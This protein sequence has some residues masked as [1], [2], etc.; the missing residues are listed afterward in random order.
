M[1]IPIKL[2]LWVPLLDCLVYLPDCWLYLAWGYVLI[3]QDFRSN[4][5]QFS[6]MLRTSELSRE[7]GISTSPRHHICRTKSRLHKRILRSVLLR[8]SVNTFS[9]SSATSWGSFRYSSRAIPFTL[10][11]LLSVFQTWLVT[12][13]TKK[14]TV[15]SYIKIVT[16]LTVENGM[17]II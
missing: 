4:I 11:A 9:I 6:W 10:F 7:W 12:S 1:K 15:E 13:R 2:C 8:L 16:C 14:Q 17:N 5:F 3:A